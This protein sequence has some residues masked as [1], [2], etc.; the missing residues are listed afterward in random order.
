MH[1]K[2]AICNDFFDIGIL[3]FFLDLDNGNTTNHISKISI[4][5]Y[6]TIQSAVLLSS[7]N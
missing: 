3:A 4:S 5:K 6:G 2:L 1:F 7:A